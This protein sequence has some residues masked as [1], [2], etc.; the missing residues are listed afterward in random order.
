MIA[1]WLAW[2]IIAVV[3]WGLWALVSKLIG[4]ALTAMQSQALSTIGIIPV[5]LALSRSRMLQAHGNKPKGVGLAFAAGALVCVGNMA[6]YHALQLGGKAS[7]VVPSTALYP[8]VTTALA[9]MLLGEK[10]NGIQRAGII[11]SLVS[12]ALFNIAGLDGLATGWLAYALVPI[13]LWGIGGLL[14]KIA[15]NHISGELS[16][17]WF[18][19]AFIPVAIILY[20]LQPLQSS[21]TG[22]TWTLAIVM[23]L[24]F[25]FG[26]L[27]LLIAFSKNGKA[28]IIAPLAGLYPMVSIP[29]A[30]IFLGE[31]I[32]LR[33]GLG[34][35]LALMAVAA[36]ACERPGK[37]K[38]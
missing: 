10:L 4:D 25:A 5:I 12:I 13:V 36:L 27:A 24:L 19:T 18:L 29:I 14:Q 17:V 11:L 3:C 9:V 6:Y 2:T 22:R 21:I 15:T 28:S 37:E 23:G 31:K 35:A 8:L 30:I 26:N 34:I 38:V 16:A 7:T 32:G 20:I 1:P 33:E